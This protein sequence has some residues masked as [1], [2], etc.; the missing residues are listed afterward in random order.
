MQSPGSDAGALPKGDK[1]YQPSCYSFAMSSEAGVSSPKDDLK[2][3][4]ERV[5]DIA[6]AMTDNWSRRL[7]EANEKLASAETANRLLLEEVRGLRLERNLYLQGRGESSDGRHSLRRLS[8]SP[9]SSRRSQS[10]TGGSP[11]SKLD[12]LKEMKLSAPLQTE[13][14]R[15]RLFGLVRKIALTQTPPLLVLSIVRDGQT[16]VSKL[17]IE[18]HSDDWKA[19]KVWAL[20]SGIEK[21]GKSSFSLKKRDSVRVDKES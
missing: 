17:P 7:L 13:I 18:A 6:R 16:S 21:E 5:G 10:G 4:L 11:A 8:R 14:D 20:A 3:S 2:R 15:A 12:S 19:V 9:Q 1:N